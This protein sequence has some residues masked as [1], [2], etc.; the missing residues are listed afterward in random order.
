MQPTAGATVLEGGARWSRWL[1]F[2]VLLPLSVTLLVV[3][4]GLSGAALS[5]ALWT[6]VAAA[7]ALR[8]EDV[9]RLTEE[10]IAV[11]RRRKPERLYRWDDLLEVGWGQLGF[12]TWGPAVRT[13]GGTPFESP[14]PGV[15]YVTAALHRPTQETKDLLARACADHHV[16]YSEHMISDIHKGRRKVRVPGDVPRKAWL[17]ARSTSAE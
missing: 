9:V 8:R 14:S 11:T 17:E 6:V 16:P 5:P 2:A 4:H 10:G 3:D 12:G 15:P 1:P 13:V 7:L